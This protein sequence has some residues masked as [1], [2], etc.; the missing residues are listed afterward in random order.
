MI[1]IIESLSIFFFNYLDG[2]LG[3]YLVRRYGGADIITAGSSAHIDYYLLLSNNLL[4]NNQ[5]YI[6][7]LIRNKISLIGTLRNI[8]ARL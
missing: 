8:K 2:Y 3:I 7:I 4:N 5:H 1:P 6:M